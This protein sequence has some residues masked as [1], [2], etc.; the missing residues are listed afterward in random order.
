[1]HGRDCCMHYPLIG[2]AH[3]TARLRMRYT[4][5]MRRKTACESADKP[6]TH[7]VPIFDNTASTAMG[8]DWSQD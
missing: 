4:D 7:I 3:G 1:M 6:R 5:A 8:P 2:P